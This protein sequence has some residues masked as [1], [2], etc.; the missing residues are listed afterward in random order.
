MPHDPI[1]H[2]LGLAKKAGRLEIGEEPVG[3]AAR[4]HQ[5][6]VLL[7]AADAA[8]NTVRRAAHFGEAGG[9]LWLQMPF[10]KAELGEQLGRSSCAMLAVTTS[11]SPPPWRRSWPLGTRS[12]TAPQLSS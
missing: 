9:A 4:A 11:G 6:R 8:P 1:L 5:A 3:A 12:G 10:T 2:L 7:L